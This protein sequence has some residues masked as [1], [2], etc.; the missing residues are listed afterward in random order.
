[1]NRGEKHQLVCQLYK[2]GKTMREIAKDVHMSFSDIGSIT[3]KL[4]DHLQPKRKGISIES[5]ALKLF[6]KR[7]NPV[8]VAISLNLPPTLAASIYKQFWKLRGLNK[9]FHLYEEVENDIGL[10]TKVYDVMK[11]YRLTRKEIINIVTYAPRHLFLSDE[12]EELE[13]QLDS[14][15]NQNS[16]VNDSLLTMKKKHKELSEKVDKYNEITIR[17]Y[18]YIEDLRNE[19]EKLESHISNLKTSDEYYIKFEKFAKEKLELILNDRRWMLA[20]AVD[21]VIE[22]MK[23]VQFK[24]MIINDSITDEMNQQ[25]LLDLCEI[26]FG[27]LL[28][29]I[30]DLRIDFNTKQDIDIV[31]SPDTG[32][33][34]E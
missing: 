9:L 2:E 15:S 16:H 19:I 25:K 24:E 32:T 29:Q 13:L 23:Q 1:M 31:N 33:P 21:A 11:K 3:R 8:D 22:S 5:K 28:K 18:S 27:K 14:L 12:I 10:V 30:I 20:L 6:R 26:L 4:N 34:I 17:K 7:R